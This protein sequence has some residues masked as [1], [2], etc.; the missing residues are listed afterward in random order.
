MFLSR[1]VSQGDDTNLGTV[2]RLAILLILPDFVEIILVELPNKAG[3]VAVLEMFRQYG[4]RE[5][6]VL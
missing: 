2:R 1:D 4:L 5:F 3:K 6:L